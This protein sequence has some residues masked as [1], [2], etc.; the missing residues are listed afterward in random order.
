[1][2]KKIYIYAAQPKLIDGVEASIWVSHIKMKSSTTFSFSL[3]KTL[4][5]DI[6]EYTQSYLNEV[7]KKSEQELLLEKKDQLESELIEINGKLEW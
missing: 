1:M 7:V 2:K 6:G 5:V 4:E 3:L